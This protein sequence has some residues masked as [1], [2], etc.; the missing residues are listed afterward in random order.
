VFFYFTIYGYVL[1][2]WI[3][4]SPCQRRGRNFA[5]EI[6]QTTHTGRGCN[7][8]WRTELGAAGHIEKREKKKCD[9]TIRVGLNETKNKYQYEPM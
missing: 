9:A 5:G 6:N 4:L 7:I 1:S 3:S 8:I 2:R